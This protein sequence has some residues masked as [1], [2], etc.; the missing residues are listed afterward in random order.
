MCNRLT[1][2]VTTETCPVPPLLLSTSQHNHLSLRTVFPHYSTARTFHV[3]FVTRSSLLARIDPMVTWVDYVPPAT[4]R[5]EGGGGFR[6]KPVT[7]VSLVTGRFS[8]GRTPHL[9][10][11]DVELRRTGNCYFDNE[12]KYL[13]VGGTSTAFCCQAV[14]GLLQPRIRM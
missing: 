9:H 7:W 5:W 12:Y 13:P 14:S 11:N 8:F 2:C 6:Q 1:G 10:L 4:R 3:C